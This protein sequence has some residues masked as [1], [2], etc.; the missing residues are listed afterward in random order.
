MQMT[1]FL[2]LPGKEEQTL[3]Y[4]DH[5]AASYAEATSGIDMSGL[6]A[7]FLKYVVP[8]GLLLDAGSGSGRDTLRL[9]KLGYVVEAFDASPELCKL[10]TRRT[11]VR[12]SCLR[13]Q[14]FDSPPWY[15][16]IWASASLLHVPLS[17]LNDAVGRLARALKSRGALYMSFKYGS[18][19]RIAR[20]GR[21]FSDM[22]EHG[23]QRL[24]AAV[25][26]LTIAD[27]AVTGEG[28]NYGKALWLN[29]VALNSAQR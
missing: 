24:V 5:N 2:T 6:Y 17:D 16:G 11:G 20:N 3:E 10:S 12:T 1:N 15:D 29:A 18:G 25:P 4:Y 9:I 23:M 21:L 28:A 13:F 7:R 27:L 22:D 26:Q 14:D 8:G 19:E